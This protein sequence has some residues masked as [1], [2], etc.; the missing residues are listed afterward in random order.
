M[1]SGNCIQSLKKIPDCTPFTLHPLTLT[2]YPPYTQPQDIIRAFSKFGNV[3]IDRI[4]N[5]FCYLSF[6]TDEE[7][8]AA[9][10]ASKKVNIY[11]EFLIIK[12]YSAKQAAEGNKNQTPKREFPRS[13]QKGN[14]KTTISK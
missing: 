3:R 10:E 4:T 12:P 11:G 2:G 5:K 8:K 1:A 7:A 14:F 13:K 9:I 6:S